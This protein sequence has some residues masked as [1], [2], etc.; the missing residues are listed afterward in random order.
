MIMITGML[1][2]VMHNLVYIYVYM[3]YKLKYRYIYHFSDWVALN[4]HLYVLYIAVNNKAI[5]TTDCCSNKLILYSY[6]I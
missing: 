5:L 6:S 2:Y 4:F 1:I 3:W